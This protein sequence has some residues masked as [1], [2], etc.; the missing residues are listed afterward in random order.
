MKQKQYFLEKLDFNVRV[1]DPDGRA[2]FSLPHSYD[3]D[4]I[5]SVGL[6]ILN[7]LNERIERLERLT[8]QQDRREAYLLQLLE[9]VANDAYIPNEDGTF[10]NGDVN[11]ALGL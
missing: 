8:Q 6:Q 9:D 1:C 10:P 2:V 5:A 7:A 4:R 11:K 3:A